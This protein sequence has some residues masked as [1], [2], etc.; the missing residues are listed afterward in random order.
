MWRIVRVMGKV[1]LS[2][3]IVLQPEIVS[4]RL[5]SNPDRSSETRVGCTNA[6]GPVLWTGF[7]HDH[8]SVCVLVLLMPMRPP[9]I[10]ICG[11]KVQVVA[12][13]PRRHLKNT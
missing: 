8:Y 10:L 12:S 7:R 6:F 9:N 13:V 3:L 2:N 5:V 11:Q 1:M 4:H